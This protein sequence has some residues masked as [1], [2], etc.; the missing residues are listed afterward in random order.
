MHQ[1]PPGRLTTTAA[2]VEQVLGVKAATLR[3][4]VERGLVRKHGRDRYDVA[5]IVERLGN[6]G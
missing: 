1:A 5:D 4:W 3:K 6:A 2:A